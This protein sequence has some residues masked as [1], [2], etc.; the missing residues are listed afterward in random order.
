MWIIGIALCVAIFEVGVA[1][2]KG[3]CSWWPA[4]L[5]VTVLANLISLIAQ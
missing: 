1:Y 3:Y 2:G 5:V 4:V